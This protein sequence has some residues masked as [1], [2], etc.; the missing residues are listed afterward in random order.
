ME[1]RSAPTRS[2]PAGLAVGLFLCLAAAAP[3]EAQLVLGQYE[4]EAPLGSWNV[5]GAVGAPALGSGGIRVARAWDGS[6]SLTNPA[7]LLSLPRVSAGLTASY[8]GASL[9][10]YSL[11]NTGVIS[12]TSNLTVGV[13][14]LETGTFAHRFGE[15]AVAF[16]TGLIETYSRPRVRWSYF[17]DYALTMIQRGSLRA[18]NLAAARRLGRRFSLGLGWNVVDGRLDRTVTEAWPDDGITITDE[19]LERFRGV[20][21]N[22]SL[23]ADLSPRVAVSLAVRTPFLKSSAG[24]SLLRYEATDAGTDIRI[25]AEARN[26]YRQPWVAGAGLDWRLSEAWS[27]A[28]DLIYF[29]WS[30]YHVLYF[31][32]PAARRFRNVMTAAAGLEYGIKGRS[33]GKPVRFPVRVGVAYDPQPM[34]DVHSRYLAFTFGAGFRSG[35]FAV[36]LGGSIGRE[37]GSGNSLRT[38]R[39][40]LGVGYALDAR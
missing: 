29:G 28:A 18:Y 11:V 13:L 5:F 14:V 36:D 20:F 33:R 24:R 7:L 37:A 21:V 34:D 27:V 17:S 22:A 3:A 6:V 15:W 32:E 19:K 2:F 35:P 1:K 38:G 8:S 26:E 23:R 25:E 39:I 16:T 4:D 30:R 31:E 12:S 40:V 9:F 10:R